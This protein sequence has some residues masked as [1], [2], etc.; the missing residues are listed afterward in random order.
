MASKPK[1]KRSRP[2]IHI[3]EVVGAYSSVWGE[4]WG[5]YVLNRLSKQ[6]LHMERFPNLTESQSNIYNIYILQ[7]L[8]M[9]VNGLC[10]SY[11]REIAQRAIL[12]D[13]TQFD[14]DG[15]LTQYYNEHRKCIAS[16]YSQ[17]DHH[18]HGAPT[19][20]APIH[21]LPAVALPHHFILPYAAQT[22][23]PLTAAATDATKSWRT[24]ARAMGLRVKFP[25]AEPTAP[26]LGEDAP[27]PLSVLSLGR[28][29]PQPRESAASHLRACQFALCDATGAVPVCV[30][31]AHEG[32]DT[33]PAAAACGCVRSSDGAVC[34]RCWACAPSPGAV[35]L[36][37]RAQVH[38][39]T[40]PATAQPATPIDGQA[41]PRVPDDT[42]PSAWLSVRPQVS[43]HSSALSLVSDSNP[44]YLMPFLS[45]Y[46]RFPGHPHPTR[47]LR[48][49]ARAAA[50]ALALCGLSAR[51]RRR[52]AAVLLRS[53]GAVSLRARRR[54]GGHRGGG[55]RCLVRPRLSTCHVVACGTCY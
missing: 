1:A 23:R 41:G 25:H 52:P 31:S 24:L 33:A 10:P 16:A 48:S 18:P 2:K 22:R 29:C 53:G 28:L 34:Y 37:V 35:C 13:P 20:P 32:T 38:V 47:A 30:D 3:D 12:H 14:V 45:P 46:P 50:A 7:S 49:G 8:S 54:G 40:P 17:L 27:A 44:N 4:R 5:D 9:V 11:I 39:A 55:R 51:A 36:L 43:I 15:P 42:P 21:C 6:R 26:S 19:L